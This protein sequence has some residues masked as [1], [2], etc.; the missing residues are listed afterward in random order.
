MVP[1]T[2]LGRKVCLQEVNEYCKEAKIL[3]HAPGVYINENECVGAARVN[4]VDKLFDIPV[5]IRKTGEAAKG[6]SRLDHPSKS[7]T[8]LYSRPRVL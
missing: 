4:E 6:T 8:F 7:F 5:G 2:G 1:V 3:D